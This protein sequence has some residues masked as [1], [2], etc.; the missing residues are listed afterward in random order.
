MKPVYSKNKKAQLI[1]GLLIGIV[2]GF[3]LQKGQVIRYEVI[4]RQLLLRDFTVLKIMLTATATGM[5]GVHFF[6]SLGLARLQPKEGSVGKNIIGGL[7]FGVGFAILGYCPGTIAGAAGNGYLDAILGGFP[8][9]VLGAWLFAVVY[10]RLSKGILG[11][12]YFGPVTFPELLETNPWTMVFVFGCLI[13]G[14][15]L[16]LEAAGL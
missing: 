9:M 6:K 11:R 4:I 2:F 14:V 10:P 12:G 7:M 15:L 16:L 5:I 8:G 3:L 1:S 13:G